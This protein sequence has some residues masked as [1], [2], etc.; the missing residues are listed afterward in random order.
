[1]DR[2]GDPNQ[3]GNLDW[4]NGAFADL[5]D[6]AK[7][8]AADPQA[9]PAEIL[10]PPTPL[11]QTMDGYSAAGIR[12]MAILM[13]NDAGLPIDQ[14]LPYDGRKPDVL[15]NQL[16]KVTELMRPYPAFRGWSW[17]SNWWVWKRGTDAARSP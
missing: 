6:F 7:S 5:Q 17:A 14:G 8:L 10:K 2:L 13:R 1:V 11:Q 12:E 16:K 4:Y 9:A 15:L 3:T